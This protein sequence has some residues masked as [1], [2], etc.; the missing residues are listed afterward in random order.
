ML[1]VIA[2]VAAGVWRWRLAAVARSTGRAPL[3]RP[4]RS[5]SSNHGDYA[6]AFF[7]ARQAL[8]VA[9]DD[10]PLQQLWLDVS[11]RRGRD[12]RSGRRRRRLRRLPS[13]APTWLALGRTPLNGVRMPRALIRVRL[14]KAGFQT[15]RRLGSSCRR[16]RYRLDPVG[17]VPPGMVRVVGGRDAV[18]SA[19]IGTLDDFWIDRFEVTNRQFKAFVDQGGYRRREYVA[20]AVRRRR[21]VRAVGR[22]DRAISRRTGQPGPATWASGTY[23]DGRRNSPS[24]A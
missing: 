17:A 18:R 15:D 20:R 24:A 7:L 6:E 2:A 14:S 11:V 4:R 23:P 10:P 19:S 13:A 22:G 16:Q 5:G 21:T 12:H 3:P 8:A 9:P 1:L